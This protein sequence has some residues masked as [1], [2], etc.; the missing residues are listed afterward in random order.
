MA[1]SATCVPVSLDWSQAATSSLQ[2]ETLRSWLA[3]AT[4]ADSDWLN[5][6]RSQVSR[7]FSQSAKFCARSEDC[8]N[9]AMGQKLRQE[10]SIQYFQRLTFILAAFRAIER[11]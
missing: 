5:L 8:A 2:S 4:S 11:R 3:R 1:T 9:R 7:P 10:T 6:E